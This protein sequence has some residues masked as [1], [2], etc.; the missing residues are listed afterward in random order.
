MDMRKVAR[1][2][3]LTK[4]SEIL[5]AQQASG[6]TIQTWCEANGIDKQQYH[7]WQRKLRE[8]AIESL[9]PTTEKM[10]LTAPTFT[11][12]PAPPHTAGNGMMTV[13]IGGAVVEISGGVSSAAVE[14]VLRILSER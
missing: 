10:A 13:R 3:R 4:W 8:S 5:R 2:V 6:Q 14:T 11:E 12:I 7:Y 9:T 1:E